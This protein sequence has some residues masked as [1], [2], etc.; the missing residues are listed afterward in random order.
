MGD[1]SKC[2]SD[3][4]ASFEYLPVRPV[5]RASRLLHHLDTDRPMVQPDR[6]TAPDARSND[7]VDRA[8]LVHDVMSTHAGQ[9]AAVRAV[10]GEVV[11]G[12][13]VAGARGEVQH[14]HAMTGQ[15]PLPEAV[16]AVRVVG[17]LPAT[18]GAV[19]DVIL[20]HARPGRRL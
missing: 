4:W 16:M 3:L 6:M 12:R 9:L 10:G 7:L 8:V 17:H 1:Q 2:S 15:S 18:T 19:G 14:D 11:P 5:R 20:D 13:L